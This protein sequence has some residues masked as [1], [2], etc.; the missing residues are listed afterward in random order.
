[1]LNRGR[2]NGDH[3]HGEDA[4]MAAST[5]EGFARSAELATMPLVLMYH[6]VSPYDEDPH[7]VCMT[8]E[9]F[10][11]Q[12]RWLRRRGLRGVSVAEVLSAQAHGRGRG[13]V[14]LTFDDGY[15]D[16]VTYA[17]P[18]LH[19]FGFTATVFV[20]AGQ[21]CGHDVW[22]WLGP[23]KALLTDDQVRQAAGSGMEIASHGLNH[24]VLTEADD[25]LLS[26]ETAGSRAVLEEL[27]GQQVRGFAY[28]WG[29]LDARVLS[30]VR[31]AGYDYACAGF[32]SAAIG[33]YAIPRTYVHD[34]DTW[35]RLD[36]KRMRS[37]LTAGNRVAV[38]RQ[39]GK[40][41]SSKEE[42]L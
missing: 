37:G 29:L 39:R 13:L 28:P 20:L 42:H 33:R 10:E 38:R 16:F 3:R 22:N 24:V 6:S 2:F 41:R 11:R 19:Q 9:R 30:A 35:W 26:A 27:T 31:A 21:L 1:M 15:Q 7:E 14:G 12:M 36:A 8:P 32:P 23:E 4:G 40:A 25:T 18:V 5:A 17:M 34:R